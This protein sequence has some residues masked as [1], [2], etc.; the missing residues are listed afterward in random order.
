MYYQSV[1]KTANLVGQFRLELCLMHYQINRSVSGVTVE[2][3]LQGELIATLTISYSE[4][5][6]PIRVI[7]MK[8]HF[9]EKKTGMIF[10]FN[11]VIVHS[12][13]KDAVDFW[14]DQIKDEL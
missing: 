14:Y 3:Y 13:N 2:F 9:G 4:A 11:G 10:Y 6:K 7:E 5:E 1:S 12:N 8:Q